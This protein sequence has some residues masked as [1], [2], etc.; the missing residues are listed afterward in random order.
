MWDL[1]KIVVAVSA[2]L[3]FEWF[4]EWQPAARDCQ[5]RGGQYYAL[6]GDCGTFEFQKR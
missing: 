4:G 2:V 1:I 5:A 6:S 3:A